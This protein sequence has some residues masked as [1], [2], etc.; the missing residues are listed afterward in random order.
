MRTGAMPL[1]TDRHARTVVLFISD[2]KLNL[3]ERTC[4]VDSLYVTTSEDILHG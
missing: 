3:Q 2:E 4:V 1:H